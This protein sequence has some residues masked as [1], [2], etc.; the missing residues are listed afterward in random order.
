MSY[1]RSAVYYDHFDSKGNVDFYLDLARRT[2]GKVL[3]L[4]VGT[5]RVLFEIARLGREVVG[6]DNSLEML[7]EAKR[8]RREVYPEVCGRCRLVFA[9]VLSFDLGERFGFVSA[10]SGGVQGGSADDLRAI[11]RLVADH[12]SPG[13]TFAFDVSSPA[14]L[15]ETRV[16]P[17]ERREL[18]GGRVVIRFVAQTYNEAA[19][20]ATID[21]LYK[22]FIP[23]RTTTVS[24]TESADVAVVSPDAITDALDYAG[25]KLASLHGDFDGAPYADDS[26]WMVV[27][28]TA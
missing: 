12:L 27:V 11:F 7:R 4:G 3:E 2:E 22:E 20:S 19:D 9:D 21:L 1:E 10:P 16:Y 14:A 8:K 18:P 5:G 28:A 23:G 24:F 15:R 26:R 6:I 17:P 25:L 13:G